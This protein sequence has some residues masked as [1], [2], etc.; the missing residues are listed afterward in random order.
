MEFKLRTAEGAFK[1]TELAQ[2]DSRGCLVSVSGTD[3]SGKTTLI[4]TLRKSLESAGYMVKTFKLPSTGAKKLKFFQT[5]RY[6]PLSSVKSGAVDIFSVCVALMGDRLSTIRTEIVPALRRGEIVIVDRYLFTVLGEYLIHDPVL[7]AE[8]DLLRQLVQQFPRPDLIVFTDVPWEIAAN[9][10]L[11]R[12]NDDPRDADEDILRRRIH[13]FRY[14]CA[15][16]NGVRI[17]TTAGVP[18]T[19]KAVLDLL[20][21]H[22]QRKELALNLK[23]SRTNV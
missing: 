18:A 5:Y 3:G 13:V 14:L 23:R 12:P 19:M 20:R 8:Y 16:F 2:A 11:A 10:I 9:R 17:N 21:P 6:C 22:L 1:G 4:R 7:G 15:C